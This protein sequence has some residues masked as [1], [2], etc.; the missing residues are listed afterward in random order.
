MYLC[1]LLSID[2]FQ[3]ESVDKTRPGGLVGNGDTFELEF[4]GSGGGSTSNADQGQNN[5]SNGGTGSG[6]GAG[7]GA[8]GAAAGAAAAGGESFS[9][10]SSERKG[11]PIDCLLIF[12]EETQVR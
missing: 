10:I 9:W 6:A 7:S 12:D 1:P 3:P 4:A 2:N 5:Q 11:R 8:A